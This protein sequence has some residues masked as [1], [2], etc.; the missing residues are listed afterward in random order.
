MNQPEKTQEK[1]TAD[2]W[3]MIK[4]IRF[5]MFT[6][7]HHGSSHAGHLHAR[8]MTTQNQDLDDDRLWFFMSRQ[9]DPVQD[10]IADPAVGLAYADPDSDTYVSV[11][12]TARVVNDL[13][14]TRA[15]WNKAAQA[16]FPG[17]PEDPDL[18]LVVVNIHH[19]HYWDVKENKLVQLLAM[20]KAALTGTVPK[21]GESGEV[22]P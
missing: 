3:A 15:L 14:R 9:G 20:A 11:S 13:D 10:V 16:W 19:A 1:T 8:P 7:K 2:L 22:R 5:G 4:D 12:G 6:T 17:G 21:L 18:A